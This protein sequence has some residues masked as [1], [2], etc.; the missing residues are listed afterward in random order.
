MPSVP[1]HRLFP[2]IQKGALEGAKTALWLLAIMLPISFGVF[3]LEWFG[4]LSS[5]G[6]A[7]E[8]AFRLLDV[9]GSGAL[10]F[11]SGILINLYSAIATMAE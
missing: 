4:L 2:A 3:L 8:P 6:G 7:L 11:L 9:E 5:I 1:N 10:V